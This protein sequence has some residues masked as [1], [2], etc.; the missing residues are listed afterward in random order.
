MNKVDEKIAP[1]ATIEP[2]P[3]RR[4]IGVYDELDAV[5]ALIYF[6]KLKESNGFGCVKDGYRV[7]IRKVEG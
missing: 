5:E 4:G 1:G 7:E 3:K 2:F 6:T